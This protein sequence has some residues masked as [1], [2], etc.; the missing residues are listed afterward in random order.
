MKPVAHSAATRQKAV[1]C[2]LM[3]A[4]VS[5]TLFPFHYH[6]SHAQDQTPYG[7]ASYAH[8]LD[9]HFHAGNGETDHHDGSHTIES[10]ANKTLKSA[11]TP[12]PL[13]ALLIALALLVP[14]NKRG[15]L[16]RSIP[17]QQAY[18]SVYPHYT[19][20]LRAPPQT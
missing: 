11:T 18:R 6:L 8:V 5:M 3:L 13:F 7:G 14:L 10:P 4:F 16:H 1:S 19:P 9:I 17:L 12:L 15:V 20:P 2:L